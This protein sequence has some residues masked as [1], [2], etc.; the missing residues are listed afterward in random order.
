MADE[1]A[2]ETSMKLQP[3]KTGSFKMTCFQSHTIASDEDGIDITGS[4]DRVSF[5]RRRGDVNQ[6]APR[7]ENQSVERAVSSETSLAAPSK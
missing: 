7:A 4:I 2:E 3:R 1:L 6:L 5:A